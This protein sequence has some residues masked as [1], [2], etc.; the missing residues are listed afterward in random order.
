MRQYARKQFI[1]KKNPK[2][3]QYILKK[4]DEEITN[5]KRLSHQHLVS[6]IGSYTDQKSVAYLMEPIADCNFMVYL[7]QSR[8][9]IIERLPSLR[10]YFGCLASAVAYL[11][12]QR[13]RHRDLKPQ[14]ILIKNH[15]IYI[16]DFG[17]ALD[18]SKKGR[19]TTNDSNAPFT[20]QYVAPEI[21]KRSSSS[22]GSASDVW[23]LGVVFL[24]MITVL[25]GRP[26]KEL[27][28]Y[29][30][31]HGTRHPCVWGNAPATHE[32]FELIRLVSTGP[33][34]DNEPLKWIK[35]MTQADPPNRPSSEAIARQI[36]NT[37]AMGKFIGHCCAVDDE[38]EEY[39][40][41]P[42]SHQSDNDAELRIDDLPPELDSNEADD[43]LVVENAQQ[44]RMENWLVQDESVSDVEL[45][46]SDDFNDHMIDVP[47]DI[48]M[49]DP[50]M[51]TMIQDEEPAESQSNWT[52]RVVI[53]D[54]CD[55][56]DIVQNDSDSEGEDRSG[57]GG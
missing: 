53:L 41:P 6:L 51:M 21:A 8:T 34:S 35:D 39:P 14:N 54:E 44:S 19:D 16:T 10:N 25:R 36:K 55:G 48:V 50:T 57:L 2:D 32:W 26:I 7:C 12:R 13:V 20:E 22:R 3:D 47:Y 43:S 37:A 46:L 38:F 45:G 17:N 52:D 24:E 40:S 5:L 1:R 49:D 27:R 4:F 56:Y 29:L 33:D 28:R 31:T 18:W 9:F 30:E 11:H 23:S 15:E 42:S